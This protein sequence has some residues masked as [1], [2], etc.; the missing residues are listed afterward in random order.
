MIVR[1]TT[2]AVSSSP[3]KCIDNVP[4]P[5]LRKAKHWIHGKRDDHFHWS[6]SSMSSATRYPIFPFGLYV[7]VPYHF[8]SDPR[9][10]NDQCPCANLLAFSFTIWKVAIHNASFPFSLLAM[11]LYID[12]KMIRPGSCSGSH[13]VS[14]IMFQIPA[15]ICNVVNLGKIFHLN[16]IGSPSIRSNSRHWD[17]LTNQ[18]NFS[19]HALTEFHW[20]RPCTGL[21]RRKRRLSLLITELPGQSVN[22]AVLFQRFSCQSIT[23][24]PWISFW[25]V[26]NFL[27]TLSTCF[28][29]RC[30]WFLVE[31][32]FSETSCPRWTAACWVTVINIPHIN[33]Y[34]SRSSILSSGLQLSCCR[35]FEYTFSRCGMS[36]R[37]VW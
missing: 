7:W 18:S 28:T 31:C 25:S 37:D 14:V 9:P 5:L 35:R 26:I 11:S 30:G 16:S 15:R 24:I 36:A 2:S 10:R 19:F 23:D 6:W 20:F 12:M 32:K 34:T 29:Y 33:V 22:K 17:E 1:R 8:F 13:C 21:N 3:Q 4:L 27:V